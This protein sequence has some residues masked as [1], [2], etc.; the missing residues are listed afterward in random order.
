L[1]FFFKFSQNQLLAL[2]CPKVL[3]IC[4]AFLTIIIKSF[5]KNVDFSQNQVLSMS[6]VLEMCLTLLLTA[7]PKAL[8]GA[9]LLSSAK[10]T[11]HFKKF[12]GQNQKIKMEK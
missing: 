12:Y 9:V 2:Q 7:C 11:W 3:E 8:C 1:N 10:I 6:N 5:K 4:L